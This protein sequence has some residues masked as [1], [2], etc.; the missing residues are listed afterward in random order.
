M[1]MSN[2]IALIRNTIDYEHNTWNVSDNTDDNVNQMS[3]NTVQYAFVTTDESNKERK[4]TETPVSI[5][6]NIQPI[7]I[8]LWI[9]KVLFKET[10][11]NAQIIHISDTYRT[12]SVIF[13]AQ[14]T[15]VLHAT[16]Q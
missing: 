9:F 16:L 11:A 4:F 5:Y 1:S 10:R 8:C 2:T 3:S 12:S 15:I 7:G 13:F 14:S 6:L